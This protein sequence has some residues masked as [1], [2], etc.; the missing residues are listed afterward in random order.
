MLVARKNSEKNKPLRGDRGMFTRLLVVAQSRGMDMQNVLQYSLGP[1]PLAL[2]TVVGSLAKTNKAKM[3]ALLE[4]NGLLLNSV[5]A[6]SVWIIDGMA[7]LQSISSPPA[8]FSLLADLVF[9]IAASSLFHGGSRVDFVAD[10][11]PDIALSVVNGNAVSMEA[12]IEWMWSAEINRAQLGG[13]HFCLM[14]ATADSCCY[15]LWSC[16]K[17]ASMLHAWTA[18]HCMWLSTTTVFACL[19]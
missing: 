3:L 14:E 4:S 6:D 1:L 5:P 19:V 16:G 10:Q 9:H 12:A 17:G 7:I 8:T 18:S 13:R 15:F 2:A 11:C